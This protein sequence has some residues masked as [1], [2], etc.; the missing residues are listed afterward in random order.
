MFQVVDRTGAVHG[1]VSVDVLRNW[2]SEGRL[3]P[4][5]TVIDTATGQQGPAG[6]LLANTQ[7]FSNMP[8][9]APAAAPVQPVQPQPMQ[10]QPQQQFAQPQQQQGFVAG[11]IPQGNFAQP[12]QQYGFQGSFAAGQIPKLGPRSAGFLVDFIFGA[13]IF[14]MFDSWFHVL[15]WDLLQRY[16]TT[17]GWVNYFDYI[18]P[19][20]GALFFLTRDA[21]FPGQSI[22]KRIA[23]TKVIGPSGQ[24]CTLVQS[25]V[26]NLGFAPLIL[27]PIPYVG[28]FVIFPIVVLF[29]IGDTVSVMTTG[30]RLL[31][32][33]AKTLVVNE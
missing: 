25:I 13:A 2:A 18:S 3:T 30:K 16:P 17:F 4:D 12:Q 20:L 8:A 26:R 24:P 19:T 21:F 28:G 15:A 6:Q 1:P 31:D 33:V 14:G 23:R 11:Q 7:V 5:M 10:P 29:L 32:G 22:G 27:I 9:P